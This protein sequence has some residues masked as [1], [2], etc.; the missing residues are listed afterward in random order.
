MLGMHL[1][2]H[3]DLQ[4]TGKTTKSVVN[5][6][7]IVTPQ[8]NIIKLPYSSQFVPLRINR[9]SIEDGIPV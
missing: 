2:C 6:V 1:T 3:E 9:V 7:E 5:F 4:A 8:T